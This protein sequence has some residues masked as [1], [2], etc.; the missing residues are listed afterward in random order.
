MS[1]IPGGRESAASTRARREHARSAAGRGGAEVLPEAAHHGRPDDGV[2]SGLVE[3]HGLPVPVVAEPQ[4]VVGLV[5]A[6]YGAALGVNL[7]QEVRGPELV[8]LE[9]VPYEDLKSRQFNRLDA[10]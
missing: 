5:C 1:V 9:F 8:V 3:G 6:G 4:L 10:L 7:P 2:L